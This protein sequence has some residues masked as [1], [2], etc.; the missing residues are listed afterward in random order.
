MMHVQ[1]SHEAA[2]AIRKRPAEARLS[3]RD[4]V[5]LIQGRT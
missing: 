1:Y 2:Q 3:F 5:E 4:I